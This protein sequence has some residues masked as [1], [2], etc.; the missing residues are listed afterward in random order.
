MSN[1]KQQDK[2]TYQFGIMVLSRDGLNNKLNELGSKGWD[3]STIRKVDETN[4]FDSEGG[5][6]YKWEVLMKQKIQGGNNEQQ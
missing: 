3:I 5:I 2:F 1:N 4:E 6:L